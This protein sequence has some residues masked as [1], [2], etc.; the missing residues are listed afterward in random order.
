MQHIKRIFLHTLIFFC[1]LTPLKL[2]GLLVLPWV[3]LFVPRDREY[4]PKLFRWFDNQEY[5][6]AIDKLDPEIDGLAGDKLYRSQRNLR[7]DSGFWKLWY[8][9]FIWLAIRNPVNYF[10]YAV[11]GLHVSAGYELLYHYTTLP[12]DSWKLQVGNT[13][14][15]Y[16]G[17]ARHDIRSYMK[18]KRDYWEYYWVKP[19]NLFGTRRCIRLRMGWKIGNIKNLDDHFLQSKAVQFTYNLNPWKTF[20]GTC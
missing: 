17:F 7:D 6:Y 3:L 12:S 15:M 4:L 11:L 5:H 16:C 1:V 18:P 8:E 2:V 10:Q 19:Y 9:R 14:N 13:K 20:E